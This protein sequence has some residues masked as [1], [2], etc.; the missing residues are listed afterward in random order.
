MPE[1]LF[2]ADVEGHLEEDHNP[3]S[4]AGLGAKIEK[5]I[6]RAF[7]RVILWGWKFAAEVAVNVFDASMKI[8]RPGM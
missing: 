1:K 5:V 2:N 8:L 3:E 4:G 7:Q 6:T